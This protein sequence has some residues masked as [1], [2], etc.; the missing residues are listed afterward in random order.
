MLASF[1]PILRYYR[2]P[3]W[4]ALTLPAVAALYVCMTV[5]SAFRHWRGRGG[6]WKGR[7]YA[8]A[9]TGSTD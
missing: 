1:R 8:A 5:D 6:G 7:H 2:L 9:R 4:R 3:S